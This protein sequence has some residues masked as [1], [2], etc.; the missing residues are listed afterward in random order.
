MGPRATY[1]GHGTRR[2]SDMSYIEQRDALVRDIGRRLRLCSIDEA[3]LLDEALLEV[4]RDRHGVP[5][6]SEAFST[7]MRKYRGGDG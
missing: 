1:Q 7:F 4:E 2:V 6:K 3:K 5:G